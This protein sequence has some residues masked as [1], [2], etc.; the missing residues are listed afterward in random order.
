MAV[1]D[2]GL[3]AVEMSVPVNSSG[4]PVMAGQQPTGW[5]VRLDTPSGRTFNVYLHCVAP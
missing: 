1:P 2:G 3:I 4:T 5:M